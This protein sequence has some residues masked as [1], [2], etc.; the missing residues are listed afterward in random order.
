MRVALPLIATAAC[1]FAATQIAS[2]VLTFVLFV[3][4]LGFALDAGTMM[5]A[6]ATGTGGMRDHRQ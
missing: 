1:L 6:R 4:A 2:P 3:L 5:F